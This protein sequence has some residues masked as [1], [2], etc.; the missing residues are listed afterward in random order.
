MNNITDLKALLDLQAESWEETKQ[1]KIEAL[2]TKQA[3]IVAEHSANPTVLI[4]KLTEVEAEIK[5]INTGGVPTLETVLKTSKKFI[6]Y[7]NEYYEMPVKSPIFR[8]AGKREAPFKTGAR[9]Q[10]EIAGKVSPAYR[11]LESGKVM[12]EETNEIMPVSHAVC[13]LKHGMSFEAY[14]ATVNPDFK[15]TQG[16]Y[17]GWTEIVE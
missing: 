11:V 10:C 12:N 16:W 8:T 4:S 1:S 14:K 9:V 3:E 7:E 6:R 15:G 13:L 5:T 17:S 2:R